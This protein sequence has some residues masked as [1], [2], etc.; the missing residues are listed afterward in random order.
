MEKKNVTAWV[1]WFTGISASGKTTLGTLVKNELEKKY[2][3]VEML[4][5]DVTRHFFDNDLSYSKKDRMTSLKRIMFGAALVAKNGVPT[6]VA[7]ITPSY[8]MR[9]L[10]RKKIPKYVE[11]FCK[12][13]IEKVMERDPKGHYAKYKLG[14]LHHVIGLDDKYDIPRHP[15]LICETDIETVEESLLKIKN[16]LKEKGIL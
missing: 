12:A 14:K 16:L 8:A 10:V 3:I 11:I 7:C 15:D 13:S 5:G 4:D 2:G 1:I 6:V 9:D